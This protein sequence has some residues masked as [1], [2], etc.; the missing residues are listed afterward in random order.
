[1]LQTESQPFLGVD[2]RV[3]N[4]RPTDVEIRPALKKDH[5]EVC[6]VLARSIREAV[7]LHYNSEEGLAEFW[8]SQAMETVS[9]AISDPSFYVVVAKLAPDEI[10]GVGTLHN[11]GEVKQCYVTPE[12]RQKG[13]G[14]KILGELEYRARQIG[15]KELR[16]NSSLGARSFYERNGFKLAGQP[17]MWNGTIKVHPMSKRL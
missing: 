10:V 17:F 5:E 6:R 4:L 12:A 1:M 16:L 11:E 9:Q 2:P 3:K 14:E 15:L 13:I 8:C 7:I